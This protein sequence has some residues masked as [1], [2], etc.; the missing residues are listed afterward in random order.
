MGEVEPASSVIQDS[1]E[2][3]A[4]ILDSGP[5]ELMR[6]PQIVDFT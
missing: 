4:A 1:V 6:L 2:Q 5:A 3:N